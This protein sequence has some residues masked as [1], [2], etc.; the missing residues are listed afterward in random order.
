MRVRDLVVL[1]AIAEVAARPLEAQLLGGPFRV[2][3]STAGFQIRPGAAFDGQGNAFVVWIDGNIPRIA[4]QRYDPTFSSL[5]G[6]FTVSGSTFIFSDTPSVGCDASGRCVV[7]W[8]A[9]GQS[10]IEIY[11]RRFGAN[12]APL[13]GEFRVNASTTADRMAPR[14]AVAPTGEFLVTWVANPSSGN[15]SLFAQLYGS[16]GAPSGGDFRVNTYTSGS[17]LAPSVAA[18]R[19]GFVVAWENSVEDGSGYGVYAQRYDLT[20]SRLG[21]E[22][23]VNS[24]TPDKQIAP[25]V[26]FDSTGGFVVAW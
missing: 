22:F 5:G 11:G 7:V 9:F 15:S 16:S 3:T 17:S 25:P 21:G 23:L 4:G 6:E 24:A 13:G 2:N 14:V 10:S 20:G 8:T 26:T 18:H 19:A 1:C 12:G